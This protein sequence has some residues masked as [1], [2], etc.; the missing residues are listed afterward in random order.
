MQKHYL[1]CVFTVT[2][3][4]I[5]MQASPCRK[6]RIWEMKEDKCT[7]SLAK[8]QVCAMIHMRDIRKNVLPKFKRLCI[9]ATWI[10]PLRGTTD[11]RRKATETSFF[12]FSYL[13]V[14]SSLEELI[15]ITVIFI[16][17]QKNV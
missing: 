5:K 12:E 16:L 8:N 9:D 1:L 2:P 17:R 10:V 13:C 11:G 14:N 7:K 3:S 15:K 4:K 6:S